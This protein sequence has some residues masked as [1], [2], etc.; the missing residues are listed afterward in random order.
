VLTEKARA[1]EAEYKAVSD[2]TT[3]LHFK[4]FSDEEIRAFEGYLRRG[5][6]NLEEAEK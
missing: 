4:G 1:L 6:E 3:A 2:E 5:L